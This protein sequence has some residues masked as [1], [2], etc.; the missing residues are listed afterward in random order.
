MKYTHHYDTSQ[1]IF[2]MSH[3]NL[4]IFC[5]GRYY[6]P[7]EHLFIKPTTFVNLISIYDYFIFVPPVAHN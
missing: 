4:K 7:S 5:F 3:F 6:F 2:V 1:L